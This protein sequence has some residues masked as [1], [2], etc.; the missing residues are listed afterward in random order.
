MAVVKNLVKL[1]CAPSCLA[2]S[3]NPAT[4]FGIQE[5]VM[6]PSSQDLSKLFPTRRFSSLLCSFSCSRSATVSCTISLDAAE[7]NC[8]K[9]AC[10]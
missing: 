8:S 7:L 9:I 10:V 5:H 3:T 6:A 1:T 4:T 2:S